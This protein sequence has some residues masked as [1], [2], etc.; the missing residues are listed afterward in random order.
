MLS[1]C[2]DLWARL[3]EQCVER[4]IVALCMGD[5]SFVL[6]YVS[7]FQYLK[8]PGR[9][10][11]PCVSLGTEILKPRFSLSDRG[12]VSLGNPSLGNPGIT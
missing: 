9:L 10:T 7:V 2:V 8:G 4:G 3:R 11:A 12:S 5:S 6:C 1:K